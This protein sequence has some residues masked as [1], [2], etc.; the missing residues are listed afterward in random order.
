[1]QALLALRKARPELR[2]AKTEHLVET[3]QQFVYRRG[4]TVVVI[5]NA[6][7]PVEVEVPVAALGVAMVG[8]CASSPVGQGRVRV[9]VGA[10]TGCVF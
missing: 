2:G 9:T 3:E 8:S 10:R 6:S 7:A 4:K 5:N 1:V